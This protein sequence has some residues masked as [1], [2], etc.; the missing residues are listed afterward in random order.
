MK[1]RKTILI[2]LILALIF[3]FP[4]QVLAAEQDENHIH[5]QEQEPDISIIDYDLDELEASQYQEWKEQ[6]VNSRLTNN[7]AASRIA[8]FNVVD[9]ENY[10]ED[11]NDDED[12]LYENT[13]Q[14]KF[15][16]AAISSDGRFTLGTT[17][18]NPENDLDDHSLLLYGHPNPS[19]SFT[20]IKVDNI[21]YYFN[22]TEITYAENEII[23]T[24]YLEDHDI[25][26]DQIL[27]FVNNE[28]TGRED[29][30]KISYQVR[31]EGNNNKTIGIRIMLDTMLGTNDGAPFRIA[32]TPITTET[33]YTGSHVPQYWQ[34]FDDLSTPRVVSVGTTYKNVYEA[35]DRVVL[36]YWGM[37]YDSMWDYTINENQTLTTD[38]SVALYYNPTLVPS[39][40]S[41]TV[42]TYYGIGSVQVENKEE[43]LLSLTAPQSLTANHAEQ[44]YTPNPITVTAL[45]KNNGDNDLSNIKATL[46]LRDT[47]LASTISNKEVQ[48]STIK[49]GE[50][51][52]ATWTI[53]ANPQTAQATANYTVTIKSSSKILTSQDK[54]FIIPALIPATTGNLTLD[55]SFL[56]LNANENYTLRAQHNGINGTVTWLS[57]NPSVATVNSNGKVVAK[58]PG[59]TKVVASIGTKKAEVTVKVNGTTPTGIQS[60]SLSE[61]NISLSINEKKTL[62][63][64]FNPT[65]APNKRVTWSSSNPNVAVVAANGQ[66]TAKGVG[67]A[68]INATT[69]VG[70]KTAQAT[71]TVTAPN[72]SIPLPSDINFN[73]NVSGPK[74][75]IANKNFDTF[76]LP[77]GIEMDFASYVKLEYDPDEKKYI[78]L[79]GN[80]NGVDTQDDIQ[81]RHSAY[82]EIKSLLN[83]VGKKT[84]REFYNKWRRLTKKGG[85]LVINA[86]K[87]MFGYV[88]FELNSQNKMVFVDGQLG[89]IGSASASFKQPT[90][91]PSLFLKYTLGGEAQTSL[92]IRPKPNG[93]ISQGVDVSGNLSSTI[94]L[95]AAIGF[96]VGVLNAYG[97][98]EGELDGSI[99][100]PVTRRFSANDDLSLEASLSLFIEYEALLIFTKKY[101]YQFLDY[102][103]FPRPR[104]SARMMALDNPSDELSLS[105]RSYAEEPAHFVA[106]QNNMQ[107][108]RLLSSTG[109]AKQMLSNVFPNSNSKLIELE[110]N[111]KLLVWVDDARQLRSSINRTALYYSVYNGLTWSAPKILD[112]DNTADFDFDVV[113][114]NNVVYVLWQ[115]ATKAF[116]ETDTIDLVASNIELR[117]SKLDTE[118]LQFTNLGIIAESSAGLPSI[119]KLV[120]V[121][122]DVTA[123][124]LSQADYKYDGTGNRHE[125]MTT[126]IRNDT[127][128]APKVAYSS[129]E[130]ITAFTTNSMQGEAYP[131]II[132][133]INNDEELTYELGI[134]NDEQELNIITSSEEAIRFPHAW[135]NANQ[136]HLYYIIGNDLYKTTIQ[137]AVASKPELVI[138][139]I[140]I[141][142]DYHIL[143]DANTPIIIWANTDGYDSTINALFY[144]D[145]SQTWGMPITLYNAEDHKISGVSSI[146]NGSEI[147]LSYVQAP[148]EYN[149]EIEEYDLGTANLMYMD[150]VP[151]HDL[152]ITDIV[153]YDV[154]QV[155]AGETLELYVPVTNQGFETLN[156]IS[157]TVTDQANNTWMD[158]VITTNIQSGATEELMVGLV[159]PDQLTKQELF[160]TVQPYQNGILFDRDLSNNNVQITI[161]EANI[162]LG[163]PEWSGSGAQYMIKVPVYNDGYDESKNV[164]IKVS[165]ADTDAV[166]TE[167][168]LGNIEANDQ[169]LAILPIDV[170]R[171]EF[172]EEVSDLILKISLNNEYSSY[173]NVRFE[174]PKLDIPLDIHTVGLSG[175]NLLFNVANSWEETV[176]GQFIIQYID[177]NGLHAYGQAINLEAYEGK[178]YELDLSGM[179]IVEGN[180]LKLFITD[181]DD[182]VISNEYQLESDSNSFNVTLIAE[183]GGSIVQGSSLVAAENQQFT[184][185]ALAENGYRFKEW[186]SSVEGIIEHPTNAETTVTM[187]NQ[188]VE[189]RAIFEKVNSGGSPD[190][191]AT[192]VILSPI[193]SHW[194]TGIKNIEKAKTGDTVHINI[195]ADAELPVDVLKALQGK[196]ITLIL[197][198]ENYQW[199][200]NGLDV[201]LDSQHQQQLFDMRVLDSK[202]DSNDLSESS[203]LKTFEAFY[204][205]HY[206]FKASLDVRVPTT[207]NGKLAYLYVIN[208]NTKQLEFVTAEQVRS[209]LINYS[210]DNH[211]VYLISNVLLKE[212]KISIKPDHE[213]Q[214]SLTLV[215]YF[216]L[217]NKQIIVPFSIMD[218]GYLSFIAPVTEAYEWRENN[219]S[220]SDIE[221]HW[222]K[223]AILFT[224]ARQLFNGLGND[225]FGPNHTMTRAMIVTVLGK[226]ENIDTEIYKD[227]SF[228]DVGESSWY[229]E[230]VNWAFESGIVQG[231]GKELFSPNKPLTR[232]ELAVIISNYLKYRGIESEHSTLNFTDTDQISSWAKQSVAS[233][234]NLGIIRGKENG[235]FD[236]KGQA[237]RAEVSVMLRRIIEYII[238]AS[239]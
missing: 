136:L 64:N 234:E 12:Y 45:L 117:L 219:V 99:Y 31:N 135:L 23:A 3:S 203:I 24:M 14:N 20:T 85:P 73:Q 74:I 110:D 97:G 52:L 37:I 90:P 96:D 114:S 178:R 227:T 36:A 150:I 154:D 208:P 144:H 211:A 82:R 88:E 108:F 214:N 162:Y 89:V 44:K 28:L 158:E 192:P 120:D 174:N 176:E 78:G 237:T 22:A 40:E 33:E 29:E 100:F 153:T 218:K 48:I 157:V 76:N 143:T 68:T 140:S 130:R 71:V 228:K 124:W 149:E 35:P 57:Q 118:S 50:E 198:L 128:A 69:E 103:I 32:G 172:S 67:T 223:D 59:T 233:M 134:V 8:T 49:A 53:L 81:F 70:N 224:T 186:K 193:E 56:E 86:E 221:N 30:V 16:E 189:I 196:D 164:I 231:T 235:T 217:G 201:K 169:T 92:S 170:R 105:D 104:S 168:T 34:S 183:T 21:N 197:Q 39:G 165:N 199:E 47:R 145:Q 119:P 191:G 61:R 225:K 7:N 147:S 209:G 125:I 15:L 84:N 5:I 62:S 195:T 98:V 238:E 188:D 230:Y 109:E 72:Y 54:S 204:N 2:T 229:T 177:H 6:L 106:N 115:N 46:E 215:P 210:I 142:R 180:S 182:V 10:I 13:I 93:S 111:K 232:E 133:E 141:T 222:A 213:V 101:S 187:P 63:V 95:S 184:I 9:E 80:F 60:I 148:F 42:T 19:T 27:S 75:E 220:F 83:M 212:T 163:T 139:D 202:F 200:L 65:N 156:A 25:V 121:N 171:L 166:I 102:T 175:N 146:F 155:I 129:T 185:T 38:S 107:T 26:I 77:I 112:N 4:F 239:Q 87:T 55:K 152:A 236:A 151:Y 91:V 160:I 126:T 207:N 123:A 205:N 41:K 206:P 94:T 116:N 18:G 43:L 58:A 11:E 51:K 122:G 181:Q 1:T 138:S 159:L 161:G 131:I 66:I 226:L 173:M 113:N 216:T 167:Q 194:E 190:T 127:W 132:R 179:E 137:G 79:I 17:G